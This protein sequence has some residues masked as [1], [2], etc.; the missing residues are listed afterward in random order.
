MDLH[1]EAEKFYQ[2]KAGAG[3]SHYTIIAYR[4]H[5][6]DFL[7]WCD[8]NDYTAA[9]LTGINGA[10]TIEEHFLNMRIERNLSEATVHS[11]FRSLRTLY[12]W[13]DL[14]AGP[15]EGGNPFKWLTQPTQPNFLPKHITF[16]QV[17]VL[18]HSISTD[19][20]KRD[21]WLNCR[22]RLLVKTLFYTGLRAGELMSL[23][24]PDM[25]YGNRRIRVMRWKTGIEQFVPLSVSLA[26]DMR[27]W[28][29][30]QRPTVPHDGIWPVAD[31]HF[32]PTV[33]P[34]L[35]FGLR[36]VL[37]RRCRDAGMK[38]F[39]AHSFRHGCAA[40]IISRGG[41]I[42]L[43]KDLLGHRSI[44]TTQLY[45]RFDMTRLQAGI[46]KIFE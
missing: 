45:L 5:I 32:R 43:V 20:T 13:V 14:R 2:S 23:R 11:R 8:E 38:M 42:S 3:R 31:G 24:I 34:M 25:D 40:H 9:D 7:R 4:M 21:Y 29:E 18:L 36:Q 12:K 15:L 30:V 46:D 16:S 44:E 6:S 22:D 28:L 37:R 35:Y 1:E 33:G 26:E 17:T 41:D 27:A 10:E 39:S 19:P